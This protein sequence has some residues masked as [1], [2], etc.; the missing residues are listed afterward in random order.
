MRRPLLVALVL[1]ASLMSSTCNCAPLITIRSMIDVQRH[2][3][4]PSASSSDGGTLLVLDIDHTI[5]Q[6]HPDAGPAGHAN[7]FYQNVKNGMH[8]LEAYES[9]EKAQLGCPVVPVE[10]LVPEWIRERQG[11]GITIIGLTSRGEALAAATTEQ[12]SSIGVN[13]SA[14]A[15]AALLPQ[16]SCDGD[17]QFCNSH[18]A[19]QLPLA[20]SE[21]KGSSN[22]FPHLYT[23]G[24]LYAGLFKDKGSVLVDFLHHHH[25]QYRNIVMVDDLEKNLLSVRDA[26]HR[27][28][29]GV[30][31]VGLHYPLVELE[32]FANSEL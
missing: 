16:P 3:H 20:G 14:T 7:T 28:F 5:F 8:P 24:V 31:F 23:A 30:P 29:R 22:V 11:E 19:E 2:L 15:P 18:A 17:N 26:L 6:A 1:M 32:V 12:L 13:L 4:P 21:E 25:Q 9:W 10:V 27:A